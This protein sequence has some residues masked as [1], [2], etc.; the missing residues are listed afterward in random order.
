[1]PPATTS[2]RYDKLDIDKNLVKIESM[3]K[4]NDKQGGGL[5]LLYKQNSDIVLSKV[6]SKNDDILEVRGQ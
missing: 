6:D 1:M 2:G 3:R 4:Q 5:M